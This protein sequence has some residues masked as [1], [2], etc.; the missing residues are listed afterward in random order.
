MIADNTSQNNNRNHI[1]ITNNL[2]KQSET[3]EICQQMMESNPKLK[4]VH[5]YK[6]HRK[7]LLFQF[8]IK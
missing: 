2:P 7:G 1:N 5:K 3:E 6:T 8:P 4:S